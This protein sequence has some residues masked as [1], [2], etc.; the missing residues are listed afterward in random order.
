M[1]RLL[2]ILILT[3][4]FQSL[5]KADDIKDFQIEELSVGDSLLNFMSKDEIV[6]GVN[7]LYK[8]KKFGSIFYNKPLQYD[9]IQIT[10]KSD[11]RKFIIHGIAAILYYDDRYS[12][13]LSK[14]V[15]L[16][17]ELKSLISS[18]TKTQSKNNIKRKLRYD[19]SG[20][21]IWSYFAFYF[22]NGEAAQVFCTDWSEQITIEKKWRDNLKMSLYSKEFSKY[23]RSQ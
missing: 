2:L 7:Y 19:P 4:N 13:C 14:K 3:F 8:N 12:E 11:D 16:T 5:T 22:K 21:S 18:E 6:N 23:L 20:K 1:K 9:N 15:I 10:I 17:K